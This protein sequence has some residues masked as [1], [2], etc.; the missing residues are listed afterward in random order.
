[1]IERLRASKLFTAFAWNTIALV[2]GQAVRIGGNLVMTRLLAPEMFGIMGL[3]LVVQLTLSLLSDIG[4]RT[5]IIQS[6]RGDR[7]ELLNTVWTLE[8][9]RGFGAWAI[10][11]V[12]ALTIISNSRSD[13]LPAG[14]AWASP[15]LPLVL[16]VTT[17]TSVIGGFQSTKM[18]LATRNLDARSVATI[19]LV[20]QIVGLVVMVSIALWSPSI[21]ALV[22]GVLAS[23]SISTAASHLLLSGPRNELAWDTASLYEIFSTGRW[24]LLSSG[25]YVL[26]SNADR[27][28][29]A[30]Y[31]SPREFGLYVLALNVLLMIEMLASRVFSSVFLPSLSETARASRA[32]FRNKLFQLRLP[33]DL[34]FLSMAGFLYVTAPAIISLLYDDRYA[35]AGM[36]LQILSLGLLF[37]RYGVLNMAYVA[38]G[39]AELMASVHA[40][41]L[42]ASVVSLVAGYHFLGLTGALLAVA[43]HAAIPV[44]YMLWLN[45]DLGLNDYRHEALMLLAWPAGYYGG[46]VCLG[47]LTYLQHWAR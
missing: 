19:E 26:A 20:S 17:L 16:I 43:C 38:L 24:I 40:I 7:P 36:M 47:A 30:G 45:R 31:L 34:G 29:L 12:I 23:A 27:Y 33:T 46:R 21:W 13:L 3:V 41:K 15:E 25:T 39:R 42:V 1:V 9:L 18:M 10:I 44:A 4:V 2:V 11:I 6:T 37:A 22:V 8:V 28:L 14:S 35:D 5:V 32:N